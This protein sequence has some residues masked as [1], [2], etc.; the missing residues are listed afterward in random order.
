MLTTNSPASP[1]K[2]VGRPSNVRPSTAGQRRTLQVILDSDG[3]IDLQAV[4]PTTLVKL[5]RLL[6]SPRL[7]RVIEAVAEGGPIAPSIAAEPKSTPAA[8]ELV[9]SPTDQAA[10]AAARPVNIP[11]EWGRWPYVGI[12]HLGALA[13]V[14]FLKASPEL[15]KKVMLFDDDE[16]DQLAPVTARLLAKKLQGRVDPDILELFSNLSALIASKFATLKILVDQQRAATAP[17]PAR[18]NVRAMGLA[19]SLNNTEAS[20][21]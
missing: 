2:K 17:A 14:T 13:G 7:A 19:S 5:D 12:G 15:A 18:D 3:E 8:A 9:T 16:K 4:K 21:A 20:G 1:K 11:P 10:A 6:R